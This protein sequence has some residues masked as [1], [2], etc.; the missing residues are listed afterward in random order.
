LT[1]LSVELGVYD[2]TLSSS[3]IPASGGSF[4]F[5]GSGGKDVGSFSATVNLG[6]PLFSWT[7]MASTTSVTRA[8]G[9][10]VTWQGGQSGTYVEI[11]GFSEGNGVGAGFYCLA[12]QQDLGFTVPSWVT[13]SLPA[14]QGDL[15]V[16]N[17]SSPVNFTAHGLNF[18]YAAAEVDDSQE[19]IPYN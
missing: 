1:P 6:A 12:R 8:N 5:N 9:V 4:T 3:F 19:E 18:G 11:S 13:E 16:S 17:V 10:K 14:G 2:A 15:D 7:N